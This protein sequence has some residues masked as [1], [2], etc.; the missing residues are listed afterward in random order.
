M[1]Q[2]AIGIDIG[3]SSIKCAIVDIER[4]VLVSDRH[5]VRSPAMSAIAAMY[6]AVAEALPP[7]SDALP[8]GVAFPGV[9]KS[10]IVCTAAHV[11]EDWIGHPLATTASERLDRDIVALNDADAAGLAEMHFGVA[12]NCTGT[13]LVLT[14]GTGIGSALFVDGQLLPN[15]E[16]GH[17]E[18][19][20]REAELRAA[21][22][23]RTE[24]GL[25]W[26]AY[27][28]ELERVVNRMHALLWPDLVVLCGGITEDHPE[29]ATDLQARCPIKVG[30][31]RVD[32]GL[33]GAALATRLTRGA[34][35]TPS[36]GG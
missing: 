8:A 5:S 31:L 29:L 7:D 36:R 26:P 30:T 3:G 32:A 19:D 6:D 1:K 23:I 25:T 24:Q 9:V 10:G 20:G 12:R 18:V 2:Q 13:V 35:L 16:L 28:S 21:A 34:W 27:T 15:T 14:L 33:V 22:R 17:L 4:G 11:A